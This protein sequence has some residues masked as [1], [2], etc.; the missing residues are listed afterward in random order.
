M[1]VCSVFGCILFSCTTLFLSHNMS[2]A[3]G[4]W[5]DGEVSLGSEENDLF[6]PRIN[7]TALAAEEMLTTSRNYRTGAGVEQDS[8]LAMTW[9]RRAAAAGHPGGMNDLGHMYEIGYASNINEEAAVFWFQ[10]AA[11][12][13]VAAAQHS[14]ASMLRSERGVSADTSSANHWLRRAA[15][16]GHASA[17]GELAS[18]IWNGEIHPQMPEEACMWWL[19]AI[20]TGLDVSPQRCLEFAPDLSEE[21]FEELKGLAKD[22]ASTGDGR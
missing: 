15:D 6:V 4:W 20:E 17:A 3:C 18:L 12:L 11:D 1:R 9:A 2:E 8:F 5:G 19:V 14:L 10:K 16:Q 22:R 7:G 13:G 21:R